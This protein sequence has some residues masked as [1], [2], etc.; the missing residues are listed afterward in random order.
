M[1]IVIK[2]LFMGKLKIVHYK[3]KQYLKI[4]HIFTQFNSNEPT[5]RDL[6]VLNAIFHVAI[7]KTKYPHIHSWKSTIMRYPN[8]EMD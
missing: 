1:K 8:E 7:D 6:D 3:R 2:Y 4:I 5:K